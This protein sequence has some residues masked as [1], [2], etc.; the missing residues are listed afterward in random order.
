MNLEPRAGQPPYSLEGKLIVESA[1][2]VDPATA[3]AEPE[4]IVRNIVITRAA[5]SKKGAAFEAKGAP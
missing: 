4:W 2:P 5:P 3:R 1:T